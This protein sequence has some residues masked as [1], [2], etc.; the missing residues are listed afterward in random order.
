MRNGLC[1]DCMCVYAKSEAGNRWMR[2][3]CCAASWR[4]H[5][6]RMQ[7]VIGFPSANLQTRVALGT[8]PP[9]SKS[10]LNKKWPKF[11]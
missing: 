3:W 1:W 8:A 6:W 11:T 9:H 5:S 4:Q 2:K 7:E 10:R